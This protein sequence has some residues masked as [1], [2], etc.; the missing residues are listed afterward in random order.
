[1]QPVLEGPLPLLCPALDFAQG[2]FTGF[3]TFVRQY[4]QKLISHRYQFSKTRREKCLA[5]VFRDCKD[6]PL[7]QADTLLDRL[8]IGV[9]EVRPEDQSL[10]LTKPVR[11]LE[12]VPV[13]VGGVVVEVG[14]PF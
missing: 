10:V 12:E 7:P 1:M 11:L 4:E 3:Q 2:L 14:C 13:V 9:E 6:D 8:E 5:H